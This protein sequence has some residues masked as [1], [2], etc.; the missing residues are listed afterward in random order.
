MTFFD[1]IL[2]IFIPILFIALCAATI[3]AALA[4]TYAII[5]WCS[6]G[7]VSPKKNKGVDIQV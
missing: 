2:G 5:M 1:I 3:C 7:V 6:R 4:I